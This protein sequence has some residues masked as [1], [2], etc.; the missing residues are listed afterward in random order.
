M[1]EPTANPADRLEEGVE[2]LRVPEPSADAESLLMKVGLA[3]PVI[4]VILIVVAYWNASGTAYVADQVPM[5]ISGGILGLGL[6]IIGLGLFIRF[7]LAW[8]LRFWLARLVVEQQ[9]QTDR[10]VEALGRIEA[11]LGDQ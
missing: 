1:T 6:A 3:L 2:E 9:A 4:G 11:K 10:L 5:L 8:L 7:S